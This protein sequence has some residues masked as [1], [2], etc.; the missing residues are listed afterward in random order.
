MKILNLPISSK[1]LRRLKLKTATQP[2][3]LYTDGKGILTLTIFIPHGICTMFGKEEIPIS[4]FSIL[5]AMGTSSLRSLSPSIRGFH[6]AHF[7]KWQ[8]LVGLLWIISI[9]GSNITF[10]A[11]NSWNVE[12]GSWLGIY[13]EEGMQKMTWF[14]LSYLKSK[15]N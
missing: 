15:Y 8:N 3:Q 6:K 11:Y 7:L 4:T 9:I 12:I 2:S 13:T 1:T 14:R 10:Q 5:L